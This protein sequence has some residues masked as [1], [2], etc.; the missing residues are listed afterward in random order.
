LDAPPE[1]R[2]RRFSVPDEHV[3]EITAPVTHDLRLLMLGSAAG[4]YLTLQR[5]VG[6]TGDD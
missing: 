2:R 1:T 4:L 6:D 5:S 3:L